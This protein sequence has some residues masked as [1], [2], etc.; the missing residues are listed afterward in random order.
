MER[1]DL[2]LQ[3]E[4]RNDLRNHTLAGVALA[5]ALFLHG[6][7]VLLV[8]RSTSSPQFQK[9]T[10][11]M[12]LEFARPVEQPEPAVDAPEADVRLPAPPKPSLTESD[13]QHSS[14]MTPVTALPVEPDPILPPAVAAQAPAVVVETAPTASTVANQEALVAR[15]LSAPLEQNPNRSPFARTPE[16]V[17]TAVDFRFPERES[18]TTMLTPPLP[19]LP[20]ADPEMNVFMYSPDWQGDL[21]RGFDTITPE[22]G[23]TSKTGFKVRCRLIII[24][25]GC[26]W[27]R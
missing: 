17:R 11:V 26:G 8:N 24:V 1:T 2:K 10:T 9:A 16:T 12:Q 19:D 21:H 23:W 13:K 20:F 18:M 5:I 25:L 4:G 3:P 6:L 15:L 14:A 27:G 7:L 22:F